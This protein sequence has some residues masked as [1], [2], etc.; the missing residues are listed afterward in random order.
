MFL[1]QMLT[2][3]VPLLLYVTA[4]PSAP[5]L[6]D[7]ISVPASQDIQAMEKHAKVGLK[8]LREHRGLGSLLIPHLVATNL[9]K[10]SLQ[11]LISSDM[12]AKAWTSEQNLEALQAARSIP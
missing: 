10:R 7:R 3:A 5:I 4:M 2:N 1:F 12:A 9:K 11:T 8:T 6:V